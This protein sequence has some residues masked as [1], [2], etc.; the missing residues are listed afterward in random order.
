M[1]PRTPIE[2]L[3]GRLW[4]ELLGC[5]RV[6]IEADFF[7]LGGHSLLATQMIA[8]LGAT[9]GRE[10]PLAWVFEYPTVT[11]LAAQV[12]QALDGETG[13]AVTRIERRPSQEPRRLSYAQ[14]RLWFMDQLDPGNAAYNLPAALRLTPPA[15]SR[16]S[17]PKES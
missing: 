2:E 7:E 16:L 3:I 12:Q 6:S 13:R 4:A 5:E 9:F 15:S 1:A 17:L 11:G 10:W 14:E 8:R